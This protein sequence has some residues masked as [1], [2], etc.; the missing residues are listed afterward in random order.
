MV[1]IGALARSSTGVASCELA[2]L[3][4]FSTIQRHVR[5]GQIAE[6]HVSVVRRNFELDEHGGVWIWLPIT[7]SLIRIAC[8]Q[9]VKLPR[10]VFLRSADAL[11]LTCAREHGFTEIYTNDRHMLA[12]APRFGLKAINILSGA[13]P[14]DL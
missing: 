8:E 11:H 13:N 7:S 10:D 14:V 5:E 3:E 6:P 4:V 9:M 12:A 2:C 1:E